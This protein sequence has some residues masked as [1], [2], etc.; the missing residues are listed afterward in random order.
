MYKIPESFDISVLKSEIVSQIVFGLNFVALFFNKGYIQI[1]GS[2]S[3]GYFGKQ[4][5]Y[6]E[7]YPVKDDFGLLQILEKKLQMLH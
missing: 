7:V 5:N 6:D 3:F 4:F 2:F 1:S